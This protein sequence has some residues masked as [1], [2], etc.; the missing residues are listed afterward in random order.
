MTYWYIEIFVKKNFLHLWWKLISEIDI[1]HTSN[2]KSITIL[3]IEWDGIFTTWIFYKQRTGMGIMFWPSIRDI[4]WYVKWYLLIVW[5]SSAP[6]S[7]CTLSTVISAKAIWE[8]I[9]LYRSGS[10]KTLSLPFHVWHV[11]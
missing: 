11:M 7:T 10:C 9:E 6:S 2:K 8:I 4:M 1:T 5:L 3:W